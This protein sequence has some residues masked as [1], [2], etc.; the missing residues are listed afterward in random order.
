[1]VTPE[2]LRIAT[3][4][5][6]P[7]DWNTERF[8]LSC[9]L[10]D[11]AIL[12]REP[13]VTPEDFHFTGNRELY[14]EML[15]LWEDRR[16]F[17]WVILADHLRNKNPKL[18]AD[19]CGGE[20]LEDL[21]MVT[22][23]P[24]NAPHYARILKEKKV[25]RR[26]MLW[27]AGLQ[28]SGQEGDF[29][30]AEAIAR[31]ISEEGRERNDSG[32][33]I[34][35]AALCQEPLEPFEWL[36]NGLFPRFGAGTMDGPP[37]S[38]KSSLVLSLAVCIANGGGSWFG[39]EALGGPVVVLGGEKSSGKVWRRDFERLGKVRK[40]GM[41]F[42]PD[43]RDPLWEWS[44]QTGKWIRTKAWS[45]ALKGI[46][47]IKPV[48]VVGD[49][50]MRITAGIE[51]LNNTQQAY[52][53]REMEEFSRE[54]GCLFLVIGHTNQSSAKESLNWRLHYTARSGGNGLPGVMRYCFAVT[55][56]HEHDSKTTGFPEDSLKFRRLL[57]CGVSKGNELPFRVW[58]DT[59]PAFFEIR[60]D[61]QLMMIE[62]EL[63]KIGEEGAERLK[64]EEVSVG[65]QDPL[66]DWR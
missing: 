41:F 60:P 21:S 50:I 27:G 26:I 59:N 3:L 8:Y 40:P 11:N 22:I 65:Y 15:A 20:G 12:G 14:E 36:V 49:T 19:Q 48:M 47:R 52:L 25:Q 63:L 5:N 2:K 7:C 56:L 17:D 43:L 29:K 42:I 46:K 53:G 31:E 61:G 38:G 28:K 62:R 51:E 30:R 6:L 55:R 10:Q 57:A 24:A 37:D 44:K 23:T 18:L 35:A 58:S 39:Q 1:M 13:A 33:W 64:Y 32:Q 4:Q 54:L 66:A 45:E 16:L 9:L 34:D